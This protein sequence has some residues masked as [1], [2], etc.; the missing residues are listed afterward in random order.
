MDIK[1]SFSEYITTL[2][3]LKKLE[4]KVKDIKTNKP[5][6]HSSGSLD[7][8]TAQ[9]YLNSNEKINELTAY[10]NHARSV[11]GALKNQLT[12]MLLPFKDKWIDLEIDKGKYRIGVFSKSQPTG[13]DIIYF[14]NAVD[15]K[16]EK[17]S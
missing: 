10:I 7:V 13:I 8:E 16:Y 6:I 12:K 4:V 11:L 9:A 1:T 17:I 15:F 3:E 5:K 2:A 14:A